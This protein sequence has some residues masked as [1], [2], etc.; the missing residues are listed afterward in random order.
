MSIRT[1]Q[2]ISIA[3]FSLAQD[4]KWILC[5]LQ[6]HSID[7]KIRVFYLDPDSA[8]RTL[9]VTLTIFMYIDRRKLRPIHK[10]RNEITDEQISSVMTHFAER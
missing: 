4:L 6:C 10:R 2:K 1:L 7:D 9:A 8:A 3:I 5:H